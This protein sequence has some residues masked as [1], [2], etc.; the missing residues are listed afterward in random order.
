MKAVILVL[1]LAC[2]ACPMQAAAEES[3]PINMVVHLI[4][5]LQT[6]IIK[7]GEDA[8]KE[9][10]K[11]ADF[12][13][14]RAGDFSHEI[15]TI[16]AE[17]EELSAT[18]E[19]Q[20]ATIAE[21]TARTETL[22]GDISA[23]DVDLK[24]A[25]DKRKKENAAFVKEEKELRETNSMIKRAIN[26]LE[27]ETKGGASMLQLKNADSVAQA[28]SVMVQASLIGTSDA[29]ELTAMVQTAQGS[30]DTADDEAFGAP[31]AAAYESK[32]G[33]IVE[34]LEDLLDKAETQLDELR[35]KEAKAQDDYEMLKQ[36]V[37]D[38]TKFAAKDMDEAKKGIAIA[39][40]T[41]STAEGQLTVAKKELA[42]DVEAKGELHHD[43]MSR[44][45]SY[46][47]E[48]KDRDEELEVLAKAKQVIKENVEG[49]NLAQVSFFQV[50]SKTSIRMDVASLKV[51]RLVR[52]LGYEQK[53]SA[54][55]QLA[56]KM[57]SA[58]R[59]A[60]S[61]D[62]FAKVRGMIS[63]MITKLED[64]AGADA[65]K[66]AFCDKE[67]G[68]TK[69]QKED[70]T[71]EIAE[72]HTKEEQA[73]S[74]AEDIKE[75]IA[76]L[77]AELS[78][79]TKSQAVLDRLR[80]KEKEVFEASKAKLE[81]GITGIQT[82]IKTLKDFYSKDDSG[83]AA[84]SSIISLLEDTESKMNANLSDLVSDEETAVAE[85]NKITKEN[86]VDKATKDQDLNYDEKMT[87]QLGK[88][89]AE[90]MSDEAMTE[91]EL[92]AVLKYRAK[93]K[94]ECIAKPETFEERKK[95]REAELAGLKQALEIL[96]SEPS[97]IQQRVAHR[98]LRGVE[99]KAIVAASA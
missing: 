12:C 70:K 63:D 55:V 22:A 88:S 45:Q 11:F 13:E 85:Y 72:L 31:A 60:G 53:S 93:I 20:K 79:L 96:D 47:T 50:S 71:D 91:E 62:P 58:V 33:G 73:E 57:A 43:C 61:S 69:E 4:S 74:R 9:Y 23:N 66:K 90:L 5:D 67:L 6:K 36:S 59:G 18:I 78:K 42:T 92:D 3:N 16:N 49:V 35:K 21:L 89:I 77:Q 28:L 83:S 81:K 48:T 97:L 99:H 39:S 8:H 52:N 84:S 24:A 64:A 56:I 68:V 40:E 41:L 17:V 87:K 38:E 30:D 34:T 94:Q 75:E 98:K 7:A 54:L 1:A 82:A 15:E 2:L 51:V 46:E 80:A 29:A 25:K 10:V 32:D 65:A 76:R 44:A 19:E 86:S 27:K 26:V 37:D 14:D 95:R